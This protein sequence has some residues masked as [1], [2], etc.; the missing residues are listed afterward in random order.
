M[1]FIVRLYMGGL[2]LFLVCSSSIQA[3]EFTYS[4]GVSILTVDDAESDTLGSTSGFSPFS[5]AY[6]DRVHRDTRYVVELFQG[7][8]T[9]SSSS[10]LVGQKVSYQGIGIG[11]QQRFRVTRTFK[12]WAGA[13]LEYVATEYRDRHMVDSD[14]FL[15]QRFSNRQEDGVNL[16]LQAA[17]YW[18]W[19]RDWRVGIN[20]KLSHPLSKDLRIF[21]VGLSVVYDL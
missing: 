18:D 8:G 7:G 3:H 21:H 20:T 19:N 5:L 13:G 10:R 12:P 6:S 4:A 15:Q 17:S 11:Y 9:I 1:V 14:G 2:A 16:A